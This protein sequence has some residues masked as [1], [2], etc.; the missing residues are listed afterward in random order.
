MTS[1]DENLNIETPEN[2]VFAYQIAGIGSRFLAAVVDTLVIFVLQIVLFL[3]LAV[4][5]TLNYDSILDAVDGGD[6]WKLA[7]ISIALFIVYWGYYI[8]FE[9][10]WNGQSPGKRRMKLRVI[11]TDG[12]PITL[13]EAVIRNIIRLVDFLPVNYAVGVVTML[14]NQQSRRLGDLAA[15]TLVIHDPQEEILPEDFSLDAERE[16]LD[17]V[18]NQLRPEVRGFGPLPVEDLTDADINLA[19]NFLMRSTDMQK[20]SGLEEK[21]L[22]L[23]LKR[24][25]VPLTYKDKDNAYLLIRNIVGFAHYLETGQDSS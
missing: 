11:R 12:T 20:S 21:I 14:L 16:L 13:T 3:A 1:L 7:V 4:T 18:R 23:L 22:D 9:I 17:K 8:F 10:Y 19:V 25:N 5:F 24:M 15:G 2:I 6:T